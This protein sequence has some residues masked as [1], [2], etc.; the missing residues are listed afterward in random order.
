MSE[1]MRRAKLC[2]TFV[3]AAL[4]CMAPPFIPYATAEGQAWMNDTTAGTSFVIACWALAL[5]MFIAAGY[6]ASKI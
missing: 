5:S 4:A 1:T 6:N 2:N 3:A